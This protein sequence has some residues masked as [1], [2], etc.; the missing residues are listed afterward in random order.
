MVDPKFPISLI[1][2]N[3]QGNLLAAACTN[4]IYCDHLKIFSVF[5]KVCHLILQSSVKK[6][7][8]MD[9]CFCPDS[10]YFA[11]L[12]KDYKSRYYIEMFDLEVLTENP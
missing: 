2:F 12:V 9:M 4:G 5:S 10:S 8:I 1:K 6:S 7:N 3:L 11:I